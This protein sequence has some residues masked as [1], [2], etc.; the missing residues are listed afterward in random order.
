[1][2]EFLIKIILEVIKYIL[3]VNN[4]LLDVIKRFRILKDLIK[5]G[6]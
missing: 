3:E 6:Q 1:M 2:T 4:S 5:K